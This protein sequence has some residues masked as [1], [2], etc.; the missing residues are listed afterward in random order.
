MHFAAGSRPARSKQRWSRAT[1]S[2]AVAYG[3]QATVSM[4]RCLRVTVNALPGWPS[5]FGATGNASSGKIFDAC[6]SVYGWGSA[7]PVG[8]R[9]WA[10]GRVRDVAE[11]RLD[12]PVGDAPGL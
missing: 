1:R 11:G 5:P 10:G 4:L 6:R 3:R 2:V 12:Q 8:D 9:G 7:V